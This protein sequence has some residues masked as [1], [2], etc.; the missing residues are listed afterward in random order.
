MSDPVRVV[1]AEDHPVFLDGLRSALTS[2]DDLRIV[3]EATNGVAALDAIRSH[4]PDVAVLDIG[5]PGLDGCAVARQIRQDGLPVEMVFLTVC[6]DVEMFD[7]ALESDVKGYL[8]KDATATDIVRC[9][10]MVA[11]GQ[12]FASPAMT[13]YLVERTQRARRFAGQVPALQQLTH[14]ERAIL[15]RISQGRR[16][17]EI[18]TEL[19]IAPK[20]VDAH[21]SN[22]CR[23]L[24]LH[25]NH[26]LTRFAVQHRDKL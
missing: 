19:G 18:A 6:D 7:A 13:T 14:H 4:R 15:V 20:T 12:H 25:G 3:G 21:R 1:I 11:R 24:E 23:K 2:T 8:L 16:S 17:K 22:I 26:A 5:L 10:R 9:V